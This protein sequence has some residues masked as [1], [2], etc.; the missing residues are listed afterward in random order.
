VVLGVGLLIGAFFILLKAE[1]KQ[2]Q[3]VGL[4]I[5]L[6]GLGLVLIFASGVLQSFLGVSEF[7]ADDGKG[8][9]LISGV[10]DSFG[11]K[12]NFLTK[13]ASQL[14]T[15]TLP[16]GT[17]VVPQKGLAISISKGT[18]QCEYA[19]VQRSK[20]IWTSIFNRETVRYYDVA[21][22][23]RVINAVFSDDRGNSQTVDGTID[24]FLTFTD[25]D[26]KGTAVIRTLKSTQ[27]KQDCPSP[28]SLAILK[29]SENPFLR[30]DDA[31]EYLDRSQLIAFLDERD[32]WG[33]TFRFK[34]VKEVA[35]ANTFILAFSNGELKIVN[36]KV[37]GSGRNIG[38]VLF[39]ITADRDYF[40]SVLITPAKPSIPKIT[41][42][43]YPKEIGNGKS[44]SIKVTINNEGDK[45]SANIQFSSN[46]LSFSPDKGSFILDKELTYTTTIVAGDSE[47]ANSPITIKVCG[48]SQIVAG[49][50]DTETIY[51]DIKGSTPDTCG[52]GICQ[53]F[54]SYLTCPKDCKQG[55]IPLTCDN[56]WEVEGVETNY[57]YQFAF[58]KFGKT[59]TPVC[60]VNPLIHLAT[61]SLIVISL[62]AIALYVSKPN[63][64]GKKK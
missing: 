59:E 23:D 4:F 29:A 27:G 10:A 35:N 60:K 3:K 13:S 24:N 58:F 9:W 47:K 8:Y 22:P 57:K 63:K 43:D 52:D 41:K 39:T 1:V 61:L 46:Y 53:S 36:N 40:D 64:R 55:D 5:F 45:G 31:I 25:S 37:I 62:G 17:K 50:C 26:G 56:W 7:R 42:V 28:S 16:D 30:T 15:G 49:S 48:V 12:A 34:D 20:V 54:E 19:M 51:I 11:D 32:S 44:A 2:N 38:D 18:S 33:S 14:G 21:S 6:L